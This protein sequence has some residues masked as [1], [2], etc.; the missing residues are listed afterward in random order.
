[1]HISFFFFVGVSRS[2]LKTMANM[3]LDKVNFELIEALLEWIVSGKHLYPP[4]NLKTV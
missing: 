2:V 3:D 1:M 4:G